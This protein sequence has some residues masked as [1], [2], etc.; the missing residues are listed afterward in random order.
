MTLDNIEKALEKYADPNYNGYNGG[1]SLACEALADL[2]AYRERLESDEKERRILG[3][4]FGIKSIIKDCERG[5]SRA[6]IRRHLLNIL[7]PKAAINIVKG[8]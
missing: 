6:T 2:K 4:E 5:Y 3:L 1:I 7:K 8:E